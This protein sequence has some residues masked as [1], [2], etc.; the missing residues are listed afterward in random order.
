[1]SAVGVRVELY[2]NEKANMMNS[3]PNDNGVY[4]GQHRG[5]LPE[6]RGRKTA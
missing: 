5:Q 3:Q 6:A 2:K 4:T 1:M